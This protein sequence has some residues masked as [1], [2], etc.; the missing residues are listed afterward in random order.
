MSYVTRR[1]VFEEKL[2]KY[3]VDID[4]LKEES[5]QHFVD[6]KN[7]VEYLK[8]LSDNLEAANE[9]AKVQVIFLLVIFNFPISPKGHQQRRRPIRLGAY[10]IPT[11]SDSYSAHGTL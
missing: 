4:K 9:E 10:P 2:D 1:R 8:G 3:Q 5:P 6:I 7:L 11:D